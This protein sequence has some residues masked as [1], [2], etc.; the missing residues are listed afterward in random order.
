LIDLPDNYGVWS[1]SSECGTGG[2]ESDI[3]TDIWLITEA[4]VETEGGKEK[5]KKK[6]ARIV[7]STKRRSV[8]KKPTTRKR[9]RQLVSRTV[10]NIR[11]FTDILWRVFY[12]LEEV[13]QWGGTGILTESV[14]CTFVCVN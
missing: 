1:S 10:E 11:I 9:V 6:R 14:P 4:T 12:I 3:S 2:A 13:R 8:K 7:M 5:K